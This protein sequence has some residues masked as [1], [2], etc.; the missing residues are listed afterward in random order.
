MPL[1]REKSSP[2]PPEAVYALGRSA[3]SFFLD[4]ADCTKSVGEH[5][6]LGIEPYLTLRWKDSQ[7]EIWRRTGTTWVKA[8]PFLTL[9]RLLSEHSLW[10]GNEDVPLFPGGAVGYFSYD[11]CRLLE[12]IPSAAGDD[13]G[14]PDLFFAFYDSIIAYHHPTS[15]YRLIST[16]L[17]E[18][19]TARRLRAGRR[20]VQM[21]RMIESTEREWRRTGGGSAN[22]AALERFSRSSVPERA[23]PP[24]SNFSRDDYL[25]AI[26]RALEYIRAGDIY[27]VNLSQRFC[28]PLPGDPY[29]LYSA[30]RKV[31]P[32]P[33]GAYLDC[34]EYAVLSASPERFL[35]VSG[36]NVVTR[37]IKGTRPRSDVPGID[38]ALA[39]ELLASPKDRAE[40]VM[41]VDVERNDL[42]R[43]CIPGTITVPELFSLEAHPTVYHLVSTVR[44]KLRPE[45]GP[46]D[47]V[48]ACFPSGSI[49][50]APKIRAM[51]IIDELEPTRRS[52]YT[53]AVG[54]IDFAGRMDLNIVIRTVLAAGGQGYLQ[55]GGG[56]VADS[57]PETEYQETLH[58]AG[59][60]LRALENVDVEEEDGL[61]L[62]NRA[63][64]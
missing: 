10:A 16:G 19:G 44:G 49:T 38:R 40:N 57:D 42:G 51:Q 31:N 59:G 11:L 4:S 37:P 54:Y 1:I 46:I 34:G 61:L 13:L 64:G 2:C 5:S 30:L 28:F 52:I 18:K 23:A 39:D 63:R 21:E 14:L 43:V 53:G 12:S 62:S 22:A 24:A 35:Q 17:P 9:E 41:I 20:L 47:V 29:R 26:E 3:P 27:Q 25:R 45:M 36:G 60:V 58:K 32:A 7:G 48:R 50:G 56:I 15:T 8:S 6:F 55:V 33:F